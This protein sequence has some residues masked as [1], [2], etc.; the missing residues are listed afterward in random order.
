MAA[1]R[2]S[3]SGNHPGTD[4][5][6]SSWKSICITSQNSSQFFSCAYALLMGCASEH[7][8][9]HEGWRRPSGAPHFGFIGRV[10]HWLRT[11]GSS[12]LPSDGTASD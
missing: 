11:H 4:T 12:P 7:A 2:G 5:T 8:R 1:G 10:S 3:G 6:G 9:A